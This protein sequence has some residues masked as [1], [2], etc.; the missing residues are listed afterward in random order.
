MA[1]D[2][3]QLEHRLTTLEGKIEGG[4]IQ[5]TSAVNDLSAHVARQN[6]RIGKVEQLRTQLLAIVATIMAVSP[7]VF[8]ALSQMIK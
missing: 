5:V 4:F 6:G 3:V 1:I 2:E 8:F 7:F